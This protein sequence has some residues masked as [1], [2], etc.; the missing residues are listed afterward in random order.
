ML[1]NSKLRVISI[2]LLGVLSFSAC[3]GKAPASP[4]PDI[5]LIYTQAAETLSVQLTQTAAAMPTATFTPAPSN[6]PP[7]TATPFATLPPLGTQPGANPPIS[8]AT[9]TKAVATSP[10]AAVWINQVPADGTVFVSGNNYDEQDVIWTLKNTG[11]TTWNKNYYYRFYAGDSLSKSSS[12]YLKE[13]VKPGQEV[14]LPVDLKVPSAVGEYSMIWVITNPDGANFYTFN[15]SIKV[16]A[17]T[18]KP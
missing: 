8:I 6:T 12:Y 17:A 3:S 13:D 2:L 5:N 9:A 7:P 4:T 10:D 1:K 11:T 15:I 18:P 16:V 14:K